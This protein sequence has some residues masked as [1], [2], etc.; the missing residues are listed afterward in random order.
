[1]SAAA[2]AVGATTR[3]IIYRGQRGNGYNS[4]ACHSCGAAISGIGSHNR[5]RASGSMRA[6]I[7]A[8]ACACHRSANCRSTHVELVVDTGIGS[9]KG[10][11]RTTTT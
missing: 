7:E 11:M 9:G 1:M 2:G 10:Y 6:E 4:R 3:N 8:R 5:I